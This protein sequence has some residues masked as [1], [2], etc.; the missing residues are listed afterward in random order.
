[1]RNVNF[2]RDWTL[3]MP[4]EIQSEAD[5][6]VFQGRAPKDHVQQVSTE[7]LSVDDLLAL[8]IPEPEMLIEG[9]LPT[10]GAS[11]LFGAPK[12]N[13]TLLAVQMAIAV[14]S[15]SPL[16]DRYRVLKP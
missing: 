1:M 16:F 9:L 5:L 3:T 7:V 10:P 14:A 11:L 15:G 12:S 13:K 2:S 8:E 4:F 6:A